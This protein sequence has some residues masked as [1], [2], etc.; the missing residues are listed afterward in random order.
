M[1]PMRNACVS[2]VS[3]THSKERDSQYL[4]SNAALTAFVSAAM[5]ACVDRDDDNQSARLL[6]GY[7]AFLRWM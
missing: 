6:L 2:N 1:A 4:K 7:D 5:V 3:S